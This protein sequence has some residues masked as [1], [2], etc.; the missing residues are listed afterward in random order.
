MKNKRMLCGQ[1]CMVNFFC[2]I[3]LTKGYKI[4]SAIFVSLSREAENINLGKTTSEQNKFLSMQKKTPRKSP[5][6]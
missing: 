2:S 4:E 3:C 6:K 5:K 1:V